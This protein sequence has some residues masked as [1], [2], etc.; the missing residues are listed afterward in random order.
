MLFRTVSDAFLENFLGTKSRTGPLLER[1]LENSARRC[2]E[3]DDAAWH[4]C[5]VAR[6]AE[7]ISTLLSPNEH[8]HNRSCA[9]CLSARYLERKMLL[10][11]G[12]WRILDIRP[13]GE[14]GV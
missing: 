1:I 3:V 11:H 7:T 6:M 4:S 8:L 13:H 14:H 2:T 10:L 9:L 12:R 5:P